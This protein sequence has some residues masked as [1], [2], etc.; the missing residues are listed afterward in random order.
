VRGVGEECEVLNVKE[1]EREGE[2]ETYKRDDRSV[3]CCV[4]GE[5]SRG[6]RE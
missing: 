1:R 6:R 2:I 4:R 3:W 5:S